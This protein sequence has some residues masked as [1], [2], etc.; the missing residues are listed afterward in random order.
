VPSLDLAA[1]R[2]RITK[3]ALAPVHVLTGEDVKLVD[4]LVDAIEA[5]IDPADRPFAVERVYA[6][7][8]GGSP[9]DI[10]ASA[11]VLPM[12]GDKRIVI[13]LRAEKFLKPKRASK[14]AAD[15]EPVES[16]EGA[17]DAAADLAPLE[18]YVDAPSTS[19]VV[20]FVASDIDRTRRFTKKLIEKALITECAGLGDASGRPNPAVARGQAI[21]WLQSELSREGR[22]IDVPAAQVLVDQSG[23]DITRL[24]GDVERLVLYTEGQ[25]RIT[26]EDVLEVVANTTTVDDEWAVVNAIS[27]GDPARALVELG[28]RLDR[29][30][31][32]HAL[33]GQLR[34]WVSTRLVE[35]D[36]DRVRPAIEALFR[37]DLA[38]KSSGGDERVLLERLVVE[39]TG[40]PVQTSGRWSGRR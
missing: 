13:V 39:I 36:A 15:E 34:W 21:A 11:R 12:L 29:G 23:T 31:S 37:T 16:G 6:G 25:S 19:S 27:A 5:T 40:R 26:R 1:L 14:A 9:L 2:Q 28:R 3:R 30:D 35:G 20:V 24:R 4:R 7:E 17:E 22:E 18:E 33:L 32:P 10:A 8:N 38:L